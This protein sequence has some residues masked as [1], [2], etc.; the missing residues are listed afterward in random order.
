MDFN[1]FATDT[2]AELEGKWFPFQDT[3]LLIA[4]SG[5]MRYRE[6]LRTKLNLHGAA[7]EKGLLD[8]EVS[9]EILIEILVDTILLGW[10]G[11]TMN[12]KPYDY[13]KERATEVLSKYK[14]FRDVVV[15]F[16]DK[17]DNFRAEAVEQAGKSS[18]PVSDGTSTTVKT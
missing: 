4:R 13:S 9:D 2:V 16:A 8:L 1:R 14:D 17:M 10:K 18:A 3:E 7:M 6:K 5:N 15:A 12:G 11:F